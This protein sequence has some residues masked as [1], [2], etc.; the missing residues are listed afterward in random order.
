MSRTDK[1]RPWWVRLAD[2]PGKTY[3]AIHDHRFGVCTL[4]DEITAENA[5]LNRYD[6]RGCY[7]T[8]TDEFLFNGG[9]NGGREW[10]QICREDRRRDRHEA[11]R[12]LRAYTGED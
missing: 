7:W 5:S 3:V 1:T 4:P 2:A 10:S 8:A 6:K 12:R 9:V 11:R